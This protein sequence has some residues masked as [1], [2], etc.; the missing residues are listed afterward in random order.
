MLK[1]APWISP[2]NPFVISFILNNAVDVI[3]R[4]MDQLLNQN[5]ALEQVTLTPSLYQQEQPSAPPIGYRVGQTLLPI[6]KPTGMVDSVV[7]HGVFDY[8]EI[9]FIGGGQKC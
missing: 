6:W 9:Y 5:T 8:I 1:R 7:N 2:S 3:Y 4:T